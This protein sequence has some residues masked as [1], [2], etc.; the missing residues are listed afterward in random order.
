MKKLPP[1]VA[2][3]DEALAL[4]REHL[5]AILEQ[6]HSGTPEEVCG[7]LGGRE[8]QVLAVYPAKNAAKHRQTSYLVDPQDQW[9]IMTEIEANG[10]EVI[11][12]YHSHPTGPEIPSSTD[13]LQAHFPGSPDD[14]YYPGAWYLIASL[15]NR[16]RPS[17]RAFRLIGGRFQE[18]RL[19][20]R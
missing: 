5:G 10:W 11:G 4:S 6:T 3:P 7:I 8:R 9:R 20:I 16:A 17:V 1:I 13:L 18:K 15:Q 19:Q 12:F 14:P 2:N